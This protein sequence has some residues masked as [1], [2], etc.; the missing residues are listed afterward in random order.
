M[1]GPTGSEPEFWVKK[2]H[3]TPGMFPCRFTCHGIRPKSRSETVPERALA[4]PA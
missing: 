3:F 1:G 2:V 4:A